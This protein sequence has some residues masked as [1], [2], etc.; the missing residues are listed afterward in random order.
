MRKLRDN[1]RQES[2]EGRA[3]QPFKGCICQ[4]PATGTRIGGSHGRASKVRRRQFLTLRSWKSWLGLKHLGR[5]D[6]LAGL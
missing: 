6:C 1:K 2:I 5:Q 3:H 4:S